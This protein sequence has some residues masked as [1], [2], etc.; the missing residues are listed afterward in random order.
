MS[1]Y[2]D[3]LGADDVLEL[4]SCLDEKVNNR[5]EHLGDDLLFLVLQNGIRALPGP[6]RR[7]I[8][9]CLYCAN[10]LEA[11]RRI[12][13]AALRYTEGDIVDTFFLKAA[14]DSSID[15]A[16]LWLYSEQHHF[17]LEIMPLE[18]MAGECVVSLTDKNKTDNSLEGQHISICDNRGTSLLD[19]VVRNGSLRKHY[20]SQ[21]WQEIRSA[22]DLSDLTLIALPSKV[23]GNQ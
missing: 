4:A 16:P 23:S 5:G 20:D 19:G 17:E 11:R 6:R 22:L 7:H 15:A 3:F 2:R 1:L 8:E 12:F 14:A 21:T 13:L 18:N 10:R 9:R